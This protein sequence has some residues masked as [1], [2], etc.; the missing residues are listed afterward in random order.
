MEEEVKGNLNKQ[1]ILKEISDQIKLGL[2][3]ILPKREI[4]RDNI[5]KYVDQNKDDEKI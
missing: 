4:F 2:Y 3:Y 5:S 1:E